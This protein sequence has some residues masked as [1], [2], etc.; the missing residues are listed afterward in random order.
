MIYTP[1]DLA[2]A[3]REVREL[4]CFD[5]LKLELKMFSG[6]DVACEILGSRFDD[7]V[8]VRVSGDDLIDK[9]TTAIRLA[10]GKAKAELAKKTPT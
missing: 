3:L 7:A 8:R 6:G 2:A 5:R 10:L 9:L 1:D 4:Q